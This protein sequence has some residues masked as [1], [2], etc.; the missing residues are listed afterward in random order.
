MSYTLITAFQK[1]SFSEKDTNEARKSIGRLL[2][3][4]TTVGAYTETQ[5]I[6]AEENRRLHLFEADSAS[7][8]GVRSSPLPNLH[9]LAEHIDTQ[10]SANHYLDLLALGAATDALRLGLVVLWV[11]SKV[12]PRRICRLL[13][14]YGEQPRQL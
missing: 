7:A 5:D 13:Q 14:R 12:P 11:Q 9:S 6:P 8:C 2:V 10:T 1:Y 4:D 3:Q